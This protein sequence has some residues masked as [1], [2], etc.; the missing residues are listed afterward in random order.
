[1]VLP[2]GLFWGKENRGGP[3]PRCL[4]GKRL[5]GSNSERSSSGSR[6]GPP[7]P[8]R[9]AGEELGSW[10]GPVTPPWGLGP[11][12]QPRLYSLRSADQ[13]GQTQGHEGP[14]RGGS[15]LDVCTGNTHKRGGRWSR[16]VH[17]SSGPSARVGL[18]PT[19]PGRVFSEGKRTELRGQ[20]AK[21]VTQITFIQ[22]TPGELG[23]GDFT[24]SIPYRWEHI[25][26]IK[27]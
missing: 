23:Q 24:A 3:L 4:E 15:G 11:P 6:R 2:P 27:I 25:F 22:E 20:W 21:P 5:R 9:E 19:H 7:S 8:E 26:K 12:W 18:P 16:P 1:M 14:R 17:G 10:G 13:H